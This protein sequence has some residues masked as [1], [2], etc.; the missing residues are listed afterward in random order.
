M[1]VE[2]P[3][4]YISG[5]EFAKIVGCH[6]IST[7]RVAVLNKV[8]MLDIPGCRP[9]FHRGDAENLVSATQARISR[10]AVSA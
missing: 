7:R 1:I 5:K 8:R 9:K 2:N 10:Q 3:C 4:D 6:P